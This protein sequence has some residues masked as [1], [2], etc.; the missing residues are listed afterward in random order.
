MLKR[1]TVSRKTYMR[2]RTM[3][4]GFTLVELLVVI[5]IIGVLVGLLIPAVQAA[6]EAA[7]RTQCANNLKQIGLAA[8]NFETSMQRLVPYQAE[9]GGGKIGSWAVSLMPGLEQAA[10]RDEWDEAVPYSD[11]LYPNIPTFLCPSDNFNDGEENSRNSY[12]INAGWIWQASLAPGPADVPAAGSPADPWLRATRKENSM[13]YNAAQGGAGYNRNPLKSSGVRDGLSNTVWFSENLQADRWGYFSADDSVR[14]RLG[15]GW[16]YASWGT[17]DP[18]DVLP[19]SNALVN[20]PMPLVAGDLQHEKVRING[21]KLDA[22]KGE[23]WSARPSS[24][25]SGL[26]NAVMA[27]G[28]V[29]ALFDSLDYHVY[30]ALLTPATRQSDAPYNRYLLEASDYE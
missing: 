28:S 17:I 29:R 11:R 1:V 9:F 26:V 15:F 12:A 20:A 13:S 7:R 24:G 5:A 10:V 30:Q 22:Q 23:I 25:H 14:V 2:I 8:T 16:L 21:R 19:G 27:D 6:R 4:T 18:S 3:R